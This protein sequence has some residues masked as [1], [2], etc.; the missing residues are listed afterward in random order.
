MPIN[1]NRNVLNMDMNTNRA[2]SLFADRAASG[3]SSFFMLDDLYR[4]TN[5]LNKPSQ[6]RSRKIYIGFSPRQISKR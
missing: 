4:C 1:N 2:S 3:E 5:Q 6:K